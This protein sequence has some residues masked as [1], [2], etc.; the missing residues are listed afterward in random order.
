M[1]KKSYPYKIL[2]KKN[3]KTFKEFLFSSQSLNENLKCIL[4]KSKS[5][6]NKEIFSYFVNQN[7]YGAHYLNKYFIFI[8]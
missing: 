8:C 4:H 2:K 6:T 3:Y 1:K 7:N 5:K